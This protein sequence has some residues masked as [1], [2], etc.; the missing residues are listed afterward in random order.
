MTAVAVFDV[1]KTNVKLTIARPDG[2][3]VETI[4]AANPVLAGP[5]YAHHDV[6]AL[7][8]WLIEGLRSLGAR[9]AIEAVVATGHGSGGVLVDEDGPVLPMVDYEQALP[10]EIEAAYAG[11]AGSFRERGSAIM[12]GASH[13]ARQMLWLESHWPEA[14]ARARAYL[15]GP[16]YWAW[17]LGG[18]MASEVTS[19]AAQS[20]L[21][22]PAEA[23]PSVVAEQ[24]G[25]LRL[26]PDLAPAWRCLGRLK[27]EL[28]AA[29]G[30]DP[31]VRIICGIHDSSAN[32]YRYQ[33][34]GLTD[35]TVVSS[36]TWIAAISDGGAVPDE[37]GGGRCCN[38]DVLGRP[39]PGVLAMAGREF[40]AVKGP[41]TG[42][43]DP[44]W[45]ERLVATGT[46]ALPTF[47]SDDGLYPGTAGRGAIEG[48]LKDE[49]AA[50]G[51]L[52]LL[53]CALIADRCLDGTASATVVLDGSFARD[54]LYAALIAA[55]RPDRAVRVNLDHYGTATGAALLAGHEARSGPAPLDLATTQP[56][57]LPGLDAYRAR[58]RDRANARRN[59][60]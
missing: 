42:G 59:L 9:H 38:A 43:A 57:S 2:A 53:Y 23:R 24:R 27:P 18:V 58:W 19:L 50:R 31:A 35:V 1:G 49:A 34:A 10:P 13:L 16:Q 20:H 60:D 32:F 7:E 39:L 30:L 15:A 5:P 21:W 51:T 25:W 45:L 54:P 12:L 29:T 46:L 48:P 14:F 28:A 56:L 36:G 41:G 11:M 47:G 8:A 40:A 6:G 4:S 52:A 26:M 22:C 44:A 3:L 55:L 37:E 33:A 17:R